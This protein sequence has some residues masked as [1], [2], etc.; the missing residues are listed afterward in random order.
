MF[1]VGI[2]LVKYRVELLLA[3]PFLCG[4]YCLYL[5]LSYKEDSAVQKPEKLYRERGLMAYIFFLIVLLAL[6]LTVDI[7]FL[8]IFLDTS[9]LRI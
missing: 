7:P 1:F 9:L 6:L 3:V 4:L 8:A 2:F 5:H